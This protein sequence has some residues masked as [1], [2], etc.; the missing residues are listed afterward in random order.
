VFCLLVPLGL[1][2]L[3][4]PVEAEST[5]QHI[6][7]MTS[8]S[9]LRLDVHDAKSNLSLLERLPSLSELE[10]TIC[11]EKVSQYRFDQAS[12]Q[13]QVLALP[14][15]KRLK[16]DPKA[17]AKYSVRSQCLEVV[18]FASDMELRLPLA[19]SATPLG[20]AMLNDSTRLRSLTLPG[21]KIDATHKKLFLK[22]CAGWSNL[23]FLEFSPLDSPMLRA[24]TKHCRQLEVLR[25]HHAKN[26]VVDDWLTVLTLPRLRELSVFKLFF[27]DADLML[28]PTV[29]DIDDMGLPSVV[30]SAS[31][32]SPII[33][34]HLTRLEMP[35]RPQR[36]IDCV[37]C[38]SLRYLSSL[39]A[40]SKLYLDG[41]VLG[42]ASSLRTLKVSSSI[43]F[44]DG[45]SIMASASPSSASSSSAP[46]SVSPSSPSSASSSSSSPSSAAS[47]ASS[48]SAS[49][50]ASSTT[51]ADNPWSL[52]SV[53]QEVVLDVRSSKLAR[54]L[55]GN[56]PSLTSLSYIPVSTFAW[57]FCVRT[58]YVVPVYVT[59]VCVCSLRSMFQAL[60]IPSI[61]R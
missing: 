37:R 39:N 60:F 11:D 4:V 10:I 13:L 20:L 57:Y 43:G 54:T 27:E 31:F 12:I 16:L 44:R 9:K 23:A 58:A 25:T 51:A 14:H 42:S 45:R 33:C 30:S 2:S 56:V 7:K 26:V 22:L 6:I 50:T 1:T 46:S 53:L 24:I 40:R 19:K 36:L 61:L 49:S 18:D 8:L 21:T 35:V 17:L 38:P 41:V 55:L 47:S 3:R 28:I 34:P 15:L 29:E 52:F 59:S 32:R 5:L 48:A